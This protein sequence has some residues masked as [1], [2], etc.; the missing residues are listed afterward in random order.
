M[1]S[2]QTTSTAK[3]KWEKRVRKSPAAKKPKK[4]YGKNDDEERRPG[5]HKERHRQECEMVEPKSPEAN[6]AREA[7]TK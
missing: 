4:E 2:K 1:M 6:E 5:D 3:G 7:G